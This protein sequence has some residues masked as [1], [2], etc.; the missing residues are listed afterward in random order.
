LLINTY[1]HER[2]SSCAAV[3]KDTQGTIKDITVAPWL[4]ANAAL[5][6]T[7]ASLPKSAVN[8]N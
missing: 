4:Q 5:T 8:L 1:K 3:Y 6:F 7:A 2:S